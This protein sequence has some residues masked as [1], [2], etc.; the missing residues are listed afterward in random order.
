MFTDLL[1]ILVEFILDLTG[2]AAFKVQST[3][4]SMSTR[5]WFGSFRYC[6]LHHS[7]IMYYYQ[8]FQTFHVISRELDQSQN[9]YPRRDFADHLRMRLLIVSLR[10]SRISLQIT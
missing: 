7:F 9:F 3:F 2:T 8:I 5:D 6:M 10:T 4:Q 1:K